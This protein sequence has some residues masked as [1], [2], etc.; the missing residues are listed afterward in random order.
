[1]GIWG[2]ISLCSLLHDISN[3]IRLEKLSE[4]DEALDV[5]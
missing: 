4:C 2:P 3:K 5:E 1:M